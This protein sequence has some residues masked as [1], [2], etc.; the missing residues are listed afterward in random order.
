MNCN[1]N[2]HKLCTH[3][4]PLFS[5]LPL[6]IQKKLVETALHKEL[7]KGDLLVSE[8]EVAE[9][10]NI[11]RDGK[12]K[13]NSYDIEGKEL[14]LDILTTGDTI[15]EDLF[16]ESR[17]HTYN[18]ICITDCKIC[19]ISKETFIN[20]IRKEPEVA[21]SLINVLTGKL[22]K[23]NETIEL[24]HEN[25]ATKRIIKFFYQNNQNSNK[26]YINLTVDDIAASTNLRRE[27]VSRKI[28]YLQ[29]N[30]YIERIGI[31]KIRIIDN[32]KLINMLD[33]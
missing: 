9:E 10:I 29:K 3:N 12:I 27:T 19:I 13:L 1:L 28:S 25:D 22:K 11:I 30:K 4:I 18:A 31:A 23:S 17:S 14:I 32:E 5:Q 16:F 6:V 21:W 8:G 7:K 33:E 15:G 24:L 26:D 20:L 2:E